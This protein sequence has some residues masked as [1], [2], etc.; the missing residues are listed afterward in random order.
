MKSILMMLLLIALMLS[1]GC[2]GAESAPT[3]VPDEIKP[4]LKP[5][6]ALGLFQ[7]YYRSSEYAG[8]IRVEKELPSYNDDGT[9]SLKIYY[10]SFTASTCNLTL[11]EKS[12][13]VTSENT[14]ACSY[15][16]AE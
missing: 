11:H 7:A 4:I 13:I 5:A 14:G 12:R 1:I 2:G 16:F 10:H 9:W 15:L 6:E 3:A 8:R